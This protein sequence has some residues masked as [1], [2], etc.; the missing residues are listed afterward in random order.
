M[1]SPLYVKH[2]KKMADSFHFDWIEAIT[3]TYI[4]FLLM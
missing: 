3:K 4:F 2:E 1:D